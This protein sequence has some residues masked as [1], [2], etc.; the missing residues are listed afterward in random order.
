MHFH[1]VAGEK[2]NLYGLVSYLPDPLGS[3]LDRTR[4]ELI[5]KCFAQ[6][7]LSVLPPRVLNS[8][9]E[10]AERQLAEAV[11]DFSSF[12]VELTDV[13]IFDKTCV[14]YL[15][16]G[17]GSEELQRMHKLLNKSYLAAPEAHNFHPHI[18]LAQDFDPGELNRLASLARQM[19]SDFPYAK[20][21]DVER[22]TFVQNTSTQ[23]WVDLAEFPLSS[24]SS[25][26]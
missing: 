13:E 20:S 6:S 21:F 22:L 4:R 12:R 1:P 18:T 3:F 19:W 11:Q 25:L 10:E 8:S 9:Q 2:I 26:A 15:G 7:H 17:R 14:I 24:G 23:Q 16:V 5:P